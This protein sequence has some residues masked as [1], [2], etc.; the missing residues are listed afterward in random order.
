MNITFPSHELIYKNKR[1]HRCYVLSFVSFRKPARKKG[2]FQRTTPIEAA[3]TLH[4]L[5]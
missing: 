1:S 3:L 2:P 5:P 4:Q